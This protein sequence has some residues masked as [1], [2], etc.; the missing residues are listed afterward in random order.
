M[1][2]DLGAIKPLLPGTRDAVRRATAPVAVLAAGCTALAVVATRNPEQPGH[3][4]VC[5][6]HSL[7]GLWCPGCGSLRTIHA[8]S[9]G[10]VSTALHRNVITIA[11]L[12]FLALSWMHWLR[13]AAGGRTR[14]PRT[15]PAAVL[16]SVLLL[17][18]AFGVVRNL[19]FGQ[20]LA[21]QP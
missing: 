13:R 20:W 16:W 12:P 3:Y 18:V 4:P 19:P 14:S 17:V 21:P 11:A 2:T 10:D 7:T 8:L 1:M 6:F 9:H 15:A 5:P